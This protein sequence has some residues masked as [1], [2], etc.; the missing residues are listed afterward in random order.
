MNDGQRRAHGRILP[1]EVGAQATRL[2]AQEAGTGRRVVLTQ[3]GRL[4]KDVHEKPTAFS[5]SQWIGLESVAFD[6]PARIG[7]LRLV[8]V[9]DALADEAPRS[10]VRL[11]GRFRLG[12]APAGQALLKG[13]VMRYLA[14]LPWRPTPSGA[15][16]GRPSR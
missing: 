2:G 6:W 10:E 15:S 11:L 5:A 12:S 8:T 16:T 3:A 4:K 1:T 9:I 7:P 14:E 13:Q